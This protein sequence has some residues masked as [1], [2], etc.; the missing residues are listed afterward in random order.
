[1]F[2]D[3]LLEPV[4]SPKAAEV[5]IG[6]CQLPHAPKDLPAYATAGSAGMDIRAAIEAP[7]VLEPMARL[8][9]PTG[10]ILQIP[11]GYECQVRARSGLSIKHGITLINCV[12]TIDSDYRDELK[13]PLV[14]LS[15]EP[16]ELSPGERIAQLVFAPVTQADWTPVTLKAIQADKACLQRQGGFGSTGRA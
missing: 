5:A 1:M 8:L 7:Y 2:V 10:L 6:I 14:N 12:G 4:T 15:H 11:A 13:V 9:V 3:A 16:F